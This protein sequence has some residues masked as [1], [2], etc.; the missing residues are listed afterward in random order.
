MQTRTRNKLLPLVGG[1]TAAATAAGGMAAV[2]HVVPAGADVTSAVGAAG[3]T[4]AGML[5]SCSAYFGYGKEDAA[6]GLV[7]FDVADVNGADGADHGVD[8]DGDGDTDVVLVVEYEMA[9]TIECVPFELTEEM[10]DAE[11]GESG[12]ELPAY[13]GPGHYV[14]PTLN[15]PLE[16][17]TVDP[18]VAVGFRV[19]GTPAEHTLVSPEGYHELDELF[20]DSGALL[21][22][23]ILDPRIPAFIE[24]EVGAAATAAYVA[25]FEACYAGGPAPDLTGDDLQVALQR[26]DDLGGFEVVTGDPA[27]NNCFL[28]GILN[29][30][31]SLILA[32]VESVDYVEPIRLSAPE[33][34]GAPTPPPAAAPVTA[35]PSFTG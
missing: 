31:G 12:A 35:A 34:P 5:E 9:G 17:E 20:L 8:M 28:V 25:A 4:G 27:D 33:E 16:D 6:M 32:I 18:V 10:W 26:L 19:S 24:A 22:D 7:E 30:L 21:E 3:V 29:A 1:M 2:A 23:G 14:Y 13:P 15:L 11:I